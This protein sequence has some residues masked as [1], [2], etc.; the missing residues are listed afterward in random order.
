[1]RVL[2]FDLNHT[3]KPDGCGTFWGD[4]FDTMTYLCRRFSSQC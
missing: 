1:L 2:V 4:R 3:L